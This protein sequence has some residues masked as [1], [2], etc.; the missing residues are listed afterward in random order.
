MMKIGR[1]LDKVIEEGRGWSGGGYGVA[2]AGEGGGGGY[3]VRTGNE[4]GTPFPPLKLN[5]RNN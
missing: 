1:K 3:W 4:S 2:T 5:F